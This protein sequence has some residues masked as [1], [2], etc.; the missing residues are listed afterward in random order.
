M[1][2][3]VNAVMQPQR[4]AIIRALAGGPHT[5]R[6]LADAMPDLAQA[7]LYRHLAILLEAGIVEVVDERPV[8]GTPE[9]TYAL[10]EGTALLSAEQ[11]ADATP[12][13]HFRYFGVFVSGLIAQ[14]SRY[15]RRPVIDLARDG[16]G[17]REQVVALDDEQFAR[18]VAE[19]RG[20]VERYSSLPAT[21]GQTRR[22]VATMLL[23][24]EES[25]E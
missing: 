6:Q 25:H 15:L 22:L 9:R 11:L 1:R 19:W 21:P 2:T 8:R 3:K 10:V 16:V 7:S 23:P 17:Y 13:D 12:D 5:T 20:V 18:F 4:L 24:L 14:F